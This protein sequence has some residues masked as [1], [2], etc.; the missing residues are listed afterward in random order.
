MICHRIIIYIIFFQ[1]TY[2]STLNNFISYTIDTTYVQ[3]TKQKRSN[4]DRIISGPLN[5]EW[6]GIS[7]GVKADDC[8]WNLTRTAPFVSG[9]CRTF[10]RVL[11]S[12]IVNY[13]KKSYSSGVCQF[14]CFKYP[15]Y[16]GLFPQQKASSNYIRLAKR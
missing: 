1:H 16:I 8:R 13:D 11:C 2:Y 6:K 5:D 14:I 3:N 9:L 7:T 12:H 10:H 15:S 4:L